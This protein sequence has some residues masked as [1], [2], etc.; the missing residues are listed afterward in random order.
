MQKQS[1]MFLLNKEANY[2]WVIPAEDFREQRI[3]H[4]NKAITKGLS[5]LKSGKKILASKAY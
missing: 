2:L 5:Q 3:S 1:R 4:L